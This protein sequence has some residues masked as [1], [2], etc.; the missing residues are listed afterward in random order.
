MSSPQR[1]LVKWDKEFDGM[2]QIQQGHPRS[3]VK[4]TVLSHLDFGAE[5]FFLLTVL[6]AIQKW[7]NG[8]MYRTRP[9]FDLL[10]SDNVVG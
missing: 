10:V 9:V 7:C 4:I 6:S 8:M 3:L 5:H 1:R 2:Q